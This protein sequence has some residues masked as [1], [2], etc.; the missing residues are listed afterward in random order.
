MRYYSRIVGTGS[1]LPEKRLTNF[2]LEKMVDTTDEWIAERTG[3]RARHIASEHETSAYMSTEAAKRAMAA[4]GIS[5]DDLDLIIVATSTPDKLLPSTACLVQDRLGGADFPAFDI[6]AACAGFNYALSIA[7]QYIRSG[8]MHN[9]LVIGT[10]VMSRI[11]DWSDRTTCVLFGDGSGAVV[12]QASDEPGIL[13]THLHAAGQYKELLHA[14]SG[15]IKNEVCYVKMQGKEV[16]KI[17]VNKLGE[18]LQ[19]TLTANELT[20]ADI[21]WLVPHQANMRIIQAMAKKLNMNMEQ[22]ILTVQEHGN[23]S[24]A[25]IPLALDTGVRDGRIQRGHTLLLESF[26]GGLA[27]GSALIR[28]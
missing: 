25:S 1:Y 8:A 19:E 21:N 15:L 22:V 11:I 23:T 12:L 16:F 24:A 9:I 6:L 4:A 13:S 20:P 2:D 26:G 10:E 14:S 7:D 28:Y 18:I 17:A 27:W 3:I 5:I